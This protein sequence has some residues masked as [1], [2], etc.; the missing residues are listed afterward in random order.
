MAIL[1]R[2]PPRISQAQFVSVLERFHSPCAPIAAECYNIVR[3]HGLDPAVALGFFAHESTFGT[4]GVAVET[5]SWGNVRK[6]FRPE[7]AIGSH[8]RNFAIFRSWQDSLDDWCERI[9]QRYIDERG[10]DTIEKAIP[11]Y[12]PSD[13]N[14]N[15]QRYIE[16]V[17]ELIHKWSKEDGQQPKRE[18][19]D[20]LSNALLNATFAAAQ[21]QYHPEQAFHQYMLSELRAGRSL[22]NPLSEQ[23]SVTVDGQ[24]YVIQVF[25]MDTIYAPIPRWHEIGRLST[26]LK[27]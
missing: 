1:F 22:G 18:S 17:T 15:V 7:R 9:N 6:A 13:D 19:P 25:A 10:L 24:A 23:Q 21:A 2:S 12:A 27:A 26:L 5:K 3:G 20:A 8:P 11:V 4:K 14:N 16:H